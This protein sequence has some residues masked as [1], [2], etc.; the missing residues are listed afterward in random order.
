[1]G[2][3]CHSASG[4]THPSR[5]SRYEH[6]VVACDHISLGNLAGS[7]VQLAGHGEHGFG[8]CCDPNPTRRSTSASR[9]TAQSPR[10]GVLCPMLLPTM[11]ALQVRPC[12]ARPAFRGCRSAA[13]RCMVVRA[14]VQ[15]ASQ[16]EVALQKLQAA[17]A[18]AVKQEDYQASGCCFARSSL[19]ITCRRPELPLRGGAC[20][21]ALPPCNGPHVEI[22]APW[23]SHA[24]TPTHP[25]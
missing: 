23:R 3:S 2:H 16:P 11:R 4:A 6:G 24:H 13:R 25:P 8:P 18:A 19:L 17:L 14:S 7:A 20:A 21:A 9:C 12:A 5:H 10:Q 1:M 15:G 22:S